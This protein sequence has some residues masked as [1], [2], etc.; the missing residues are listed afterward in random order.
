MRV[1]HVLARADE[2]RTHGRPQALGE[3]DAERIERRGQVGHV[4]AGRHAGIPNARAV[5][6]QPQAAVAGGGG[7]PLDLRSWEDPSASAVVRVLYHYQPRARKVILW[8][9]D[10]LQQL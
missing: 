5:Q 10:D 9:L 4:D 3:A 6:M 7:N 8:R 1:H 2:S